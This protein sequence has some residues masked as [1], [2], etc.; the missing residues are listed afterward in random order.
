MHGC[1]VA[2]HTEQHAQEKST[3]PSPKWA[4][5][6]FLKAVCNNLH[7]KMLAV[8][9]KREFIF[10]RKSAE[11]GWC[12]RARGYSIRWWLGQQGLSQRAFT[13]QQ[14][15]LWDMHEHV[16]AHA[17]HI[18]VHRAIYSSHVYTHANYHVFSCASICMT[19]NVS[20]RV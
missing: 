1:T 15:A 14:Q 8:M 16:Y 10:Q 7:V 18:S 11:P 6:G 3:A 20:Q 17:M 9:D 4:H 5:I 19:T 12:G 13:Q 2:A